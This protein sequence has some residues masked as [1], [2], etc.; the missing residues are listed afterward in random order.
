M[1]QK[2]VKNQKA[3]Q[4]RA[5]KWASEYA[6]LKTG[7]TVSKM[8]KR[9]SAAALALLM[10]LSSSFAASNRKYTVTVTA[11]LAE[12]NH[13]GN[14]WRVSCTI[15]GQELFLGQEQDPKVYVAEGYIRK[16]EKEKV[17]GTDKVTLSTGDKLVIET[18]VSEYDKDY[19]EDA[20]DVTIR[21]IK[22]DDMSGFVIEVTI[23]IYEN[24]GRY[25]G[26]AAKWVIT[27]EFK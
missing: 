5:S 8:K 27:Y 13:V 26:N 19:P 25:E 1:G 18:V 11:I 23:T 7:R 22:A 15:N 2:R 16:P 20:T 24:A 12:N 21:T 4:K 10:L 14:E 17:L 3:V 9:L 6:G